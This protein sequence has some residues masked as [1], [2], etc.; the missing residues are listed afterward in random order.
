ML[1]CQSKRVV[2]DGRDQDRQH[3]TTRRRSAGSRMARIS[4]GIGRRR[5]RGPGRETEVVDATDD[6]G[7]HSDVGGGAGAPIE[8]GR[9]GDC[10]A[11]VELAANAPFVGQG[12]HASPPGRPSGW[13]RFWFNHAVRGTGSG[14]GGIRT[15]E[16]AFSPLPV[17]K[18]GAFNRSATPPGGSKIARNAPAPGAAS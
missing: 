8:S 5:S 1:R 7:D 17:F 9:L 12:E 18:T 13:A 10:W 16:R 11:A 6:L 15:L 4:P 2:N 14:G 3:P